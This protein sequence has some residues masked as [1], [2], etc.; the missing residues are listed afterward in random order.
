MILPVAIK[1]DWHVRN[2]AKSLFLKKVFVG[3]KDINVGIWHDSI[4]SL[5][6]L[7]LLLNHVYTVNI[8]SIA[9]SCLFFNSFNQHIKKIGY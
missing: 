7:L 2:A 4:F 3:A 9:I 1:N 6:K 5:E 8:Y